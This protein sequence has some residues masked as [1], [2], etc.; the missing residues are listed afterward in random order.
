MSNQVQIFNNPGVPI[1]KSRHPK[2]ENTCGF[3]KSHKMAM[4]PTSGHRSNSSCQAELNY[5]AKGPHSQ[6][7]RCSKLPK[8]PTQSLGTPKLTHLRGGPHTSLGADT[9]GCVDSKAK[10]CKLLMNPHY[11]ILYG[12][13]LR[14]AKNPQGT[15]MLSCLCSSISQILPGTTRVQEGQ[16]RLLCR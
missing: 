5:V 2:A 10:L 8:K 11:T 3:D 13:A 9:V 6:A 4:R 16:K 7:A 15:C 1:S 14:F 12:I